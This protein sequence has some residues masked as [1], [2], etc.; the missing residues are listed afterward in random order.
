MGTSLLP[1]CLFDLDERD[2]PAGGAARRCVGRE[3]GPEKDE[4]EPDSDGEQRDPE[5]QRRRKEEVS[6]P[7]AEDGGNAG[8]SGAC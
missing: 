4:G 1:D 5:W 7:D 3:Y 6:Q 8:E 2:A